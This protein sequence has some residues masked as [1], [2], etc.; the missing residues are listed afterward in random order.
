M[1]VDFDTFVDWA[2]S[3]FDSVKVT[4][5]EVRINSIFAESDKKHHL[6]CNP[7]GGKGKVSSGVYHCWKSEKKGTLIGLVMLV[8]KCD[9]KTALNT[10]KLKNTS[11]KPIES[12]DF[13]DEIQDENFT[14][15]LGKTNW[16]VL[17][18]PPN[19]SLIDKC[20]ENWYQKCKNYLSN[21]KLT[22]QGLYFCTGGKY[23]GRI[24][25]P[26]YSPDN[27][28][29]YFNGRTI[30]DHELRYRGP[31]KDV[32]VGKEDVLFFTSYPNPGEKIFLCEGEFDAMS[33]S[34]AGLVGVACGGKNLSDK[35][36]SY[37]SQYKV[38]LALDADAAGQSAI[39]S[40]LSKL[41]A[42]CS[43]S[44]IKRMTTVSPPADCKD[45]NE[46]LCKY[47]A[48]IMKA[49]IEKSEKELESET[50]YAVR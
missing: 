27:K 17:T 31:E 4:G 21:R 13:D 48:K 47:N 29:I 43:I 15:L 49:Y 3:R 5:Q 32:G 50:P 8:D 35:Q 37:L 45:W 7:S 41:N 2:E 12:I 28:L 30:V 19:T 16:K 40:M 14:E 38:C 10:L 11:G 6:Y 1:A 33:L 9:L 18:L 46:L 39:N 25:I 23:Y 26:Y 36:A 24:I 42:Y 44:Q 20:P 34:Q 22:T